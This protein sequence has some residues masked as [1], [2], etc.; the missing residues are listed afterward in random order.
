MSISVPDLEKGFDT[1]DDAVRQL[2]SQVANILDKLNSGK[3]DNGE[4]NFSSTV[5]A[6]S[7][8][9]N[10]KERQSYLAKQL[11][12]L[13]KNLAA[14]EDTIDPRYTDASTKAM[15]QA[16]SPLPGTAGAIDGDNYAGARESA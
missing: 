15:A 3:L 16:F 7:L 5:A 2:S 10:V 4:K 6:K 14:I 9:A 11:L 13:G 12:I 8:F 1:L